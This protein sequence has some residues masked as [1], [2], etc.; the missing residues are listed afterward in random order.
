MLNVQFNDNESKS[1][2]FISYLSILTTVE[3]MVGWTKLRRIASLDDLRVPS[4]LRPFTYHVQFILR[5]T[6]FFR[7]LDY[8]DVCYYVPAN[9]LQ[10][11]ILHKAM[12]SSCSYLYPGFHHDYPD[13]CEYQAPYSTGRYQPYPIRELAG[14]LLHR[15]RPSSS[16]HPV[17][18]GPSLWAG[19]TLAPPSLQRKTLVTRLHI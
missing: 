10:R 15:S 14:A 4:P 17:P 8:M 11:V 9:Q 13:D 19:Y 2:T 12:A 6:T 5:R 16:A 3:P 7:D 1:I 18:P